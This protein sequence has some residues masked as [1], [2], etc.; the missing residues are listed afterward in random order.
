MAMWPTVDFS[1]SIDVISKILTDSFNGTENEQPSSG[2]NQEVNDMN[3]DSF[4]SDGVEDVAGATNPLEMH[5]RNPISNLHHAPNTEPDQQVTVGEQIH[6]QPTHGLVNALQHSERPPNGQIPEAQMSP[7]TRQSAISLAASIERPRTRKSSKGRWTT[8]EDDKLR[9]IVSPNCEMSWKNVANA[10]NLALP[11][12][13]R[14]R[15]Q[16]MHRWQKVLRPGLKKGGWSEDEDST[17]R[18]LVEIHGTHKWALFE[19]YIPGRL[20]K[21]CRERWH[22]VLDPSIKSGPWSEEEEKLLTECRI[23]F[24]NRWVEIAKLIPGRPANSVKN[25]FHAMRRHAE[26]KMSAQTS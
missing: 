23:K 14:T 12:S 24:G 5:A 11:S 25:K 17:L 13:N 10:L 22:E 4:T 6:Q 26:I 19:K 18:S 20:G 2:V 8:E 21:Q 9:E 7:V 1:G 3:V 16:C 15:T